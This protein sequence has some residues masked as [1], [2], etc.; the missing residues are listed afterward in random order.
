MT[1][2]ALK[3][4]L[5]DWRRFAPAAV[6]VGFSGLLVLLQA[7]LILGVFSLAGVYVTRGAKYRPWSPDWRDD[8]THP[9][10]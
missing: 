10:R 7:G 5:F 1:S 2:I 4:L 9:A 8:R 6:A 3:T